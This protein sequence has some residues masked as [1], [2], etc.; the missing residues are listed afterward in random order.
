VRGLVTFYLICGLGALA[1]IGIAD[2][3]Y[4]TERRWWLAGIAGAAIGAL[5][6]YVASSLFTWRQRPGLAGSSA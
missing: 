1:N 3:V 2:L 5:W 6:N 4:S